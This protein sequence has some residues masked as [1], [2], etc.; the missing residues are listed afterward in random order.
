[1]KTFVF[2][3]VVEPDENRFYAEVPALKGCHSWGY[4]YEEALKNIKEAAQLWI[5][6]MEEEGETIPKENIEEIKKAPI[7]IAIVPSLI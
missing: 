1:M 7:T 3:V 2:R 6:V 4:T 5:E